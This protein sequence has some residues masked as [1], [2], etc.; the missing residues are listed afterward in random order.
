VTFKVD[1]DLLEK[2]DTYARLKGM[3]R[4]EAIRKA[5]IKLLNEEYREVTPE[6][7]IVKIYG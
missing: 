5:I 7:K 6:P 2:L 3:T 4:S 1:E